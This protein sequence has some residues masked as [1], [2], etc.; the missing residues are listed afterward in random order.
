MGSGQAGAVRAQ[1]EGCSRQRE[2]PTQRPNG[3]QR[4][5]GGSGGARALGFRVR[6]GGLGRWAQVCAGLETSTVTEGGM[7][8][9]CRAVACGGAKLGQRDTG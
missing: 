9:E 3:L 1:W 6:A 8:S 4:A 7:R 2:Q 5:V